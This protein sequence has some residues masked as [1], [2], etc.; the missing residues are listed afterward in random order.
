[1]ETGGA[2]HFAILSF[3]YKIVFPDFAFYMS[4]D[5]SRTLF[6]RHAKEKGIGGH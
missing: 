1:M 6:E 4:Y 2:W 3:T 5:D